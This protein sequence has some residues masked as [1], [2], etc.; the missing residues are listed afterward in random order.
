MGGL[1]QLHVTPMELAD[2]GQWILTYMADAA[3]NG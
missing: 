1:Q 3:V 2:F